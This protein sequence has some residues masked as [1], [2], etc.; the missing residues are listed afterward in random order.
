MT[1]LFKLKATDDGSYTF[2]SPTFE[3]LFH[4]HSGAKQ[5]A[6]KKFIE[7]CQLY[8][9]AQTLNQIT[10]LDICYGLG[11]NSAAA[12]SAIWSVNPAC[13][14]TLI[15]LEFDANVP[16]QA[17]QNQL[18]AQWTAPIPQLL[19]RLARDKEI[20][21]DTLKATLYINDARKN[22][23]LLQN[24][25]KADAIFL[26][27]FSPPK[28]PQLW[29]VE[30]LKCVAHCLKPEGY[31][32][33]YSSAAAVRI[34]LQL[35][36]LKIGSTQGVGRRSPGTVASFQGTRLPPLSLEE[37]EHLNTR[38]AITYRDPTLQ[39][40]KDAILEQR[41]QEQAISSLETSSQWKKRWQNK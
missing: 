26:D 4:S 38:A 18:L 40:T 36:G 30:F 35:A 8:Q 3:E 9:K 33:T 13:H 24:Q 19:S 28:C 17:S 37:T 21:T 1:D 29:T 5:E 2:F 31:L 16:E 7:P 39:G 6:E 27:P 32:A 10:L 22:I 23:Q 20:T 14:I 34:A 11:Y 12:L 41:K 15:A 25:L